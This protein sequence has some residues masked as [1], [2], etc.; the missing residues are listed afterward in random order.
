MQHLKKLKILSPEGPCKNVS[1]GPTAALDGPEPTLQ[2]VYSPKAVP[3]VQKRS[4]N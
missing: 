3:L 1:L 4:K 2:I